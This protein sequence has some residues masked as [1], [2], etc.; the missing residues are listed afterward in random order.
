MTDHTIGNQVSYTPHK[1]FSAGF[2][3]TFALMT[4]DFHLQNVGTECY[5]FCVIRLPTT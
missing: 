5:V 2:F 3:S 1:F 4:F